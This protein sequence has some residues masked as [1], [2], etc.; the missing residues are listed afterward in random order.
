LNIRKNTILQ[1][2]PYLG[3][4]ALS[5][6]LAP[7]MVSRLG[8]ASVGVWAVTGAVVQYAALLDLGVTRATTRFVA[9][10]HGQ[11]DLPS[12]HRVVTFAAVV[13]GSLGL[14]LLIAVAA[15]APTINGWLDTGLNSSD[16]R[17]TR[18][19]GRRWAI[20]TRSGSAAWCSTVYAAWPP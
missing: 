13:L 19:D 8:V 12:A 2:L 7:L 17:L 16:A 15:L 1:A 18:S 3:S 5:F 9:L 6:L 10:H 11:G 4:S 20:P 14:M